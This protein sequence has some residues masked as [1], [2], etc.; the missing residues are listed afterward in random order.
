MG[1]RND[2]RKAVGQERGRRVGELVGMHERQGFNSA[3]FALRDDMAAL[4]LGEGPP[5]NV[6]Q[7]GQ[8]EAEKIFILV[9]ELINPDQ[10]RAS[11]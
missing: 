11:T 5:A 9:A 2:D 10:V 7:P 1:E 6:P 8:E 4:A 3:H